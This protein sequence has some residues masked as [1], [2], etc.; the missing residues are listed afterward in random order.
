MALISAN[1]PLPLQ[2][3]YNT[4]DLGGY[5]AGPGAVCAG[6]FLR[7][8]QPAGLGEGDLE[9]LYR[10]GVRLSIDLRSGEECRRAPSSLR[11]YRD[12]RCE[13]VPLLDNLQSSLAAGET[14]GLPDSM[15]ALYVS[16]LRDSQPS[17]ARALSLMAGC[18]EGCVLYHCTAGK[19]RTGVLSMLLLFLAGVEEAVIVADYAA[20]E[21]NMAPFFAKQRAALEKLAPGGIPEG[22]FSSAPENMEMALA[23]LRRQGGA[24]EYLRAIGLT[25]GEIGALR[26]RLLAE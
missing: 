24:E 11:G 8:D 18:R 22:A 19:D 3:T 14:A 16:L 17:L 12:I 7:S 10:Y 4:R 20:S 21:A 1:A 9:A 25:G 13:E 15:G 2:G 23:E 26:A 5:P 6:R